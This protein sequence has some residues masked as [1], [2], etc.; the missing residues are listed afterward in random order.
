MRTGFKAILYYA[1]LLLLVYSEELVFQLYA[2]I[3]AVSVTLT[4][5]NDYNKEEYALFYAYHIAVIVRTLCD[6]CLAVY[7]RDPFLI[8]LVVVLNTL[9][10]AMT[11]HLGS[12][13]WD[14]TIATA[15]KDCMVTFLLVMAVG[16]VHKDQRLL[17]E[18]NV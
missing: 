15:C 18:K 2:T 9:V 11:G 13:S 16:Q 7:V 10:M 14:Y 5:M 3:I 6:M 4:L 12:S 1:P 17:L 8:V